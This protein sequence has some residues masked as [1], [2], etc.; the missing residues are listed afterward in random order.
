MALNNRR[1]KN[2][3]DLPIHTTDDDEIKEAKEPRCWFC[4]L[5]P[6]LA[7]YA[8]HTAATFLYPIVFPNQSPYIVNPIENVN[9]S[10]NLVSSDV[11]HSNHEWFSSIF[12]EVRSSN[13]MLVHQPFFWTSLAQIADVRIGNWNKATKGFAKVADRSKLWSD[14]QE[15]EVTN[16]GKTAVVFAKCSLCTLLKANRSNIKGPYIIMGTFNDNW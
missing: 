2:Q 6:F 3:L 15:W 12:E 9:F 4:W 14:L 16:E 10:N 7:A 8:S 1:S 5:W 11:S 13:D